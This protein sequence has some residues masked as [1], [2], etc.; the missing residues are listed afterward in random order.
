MIAGIAGPNPSEGVEVRLLCLCC[1][2]SE[3]CV[4]MITRS[5][6]SYSV[7]V[8]VFG[9]GIETSKMKRLRPELGFYTTE[10][11]NTFI[12]YLRRKY[13]SRA[14]TNPDNMMFIIQIRSVHNS[15]MLNAVRFYS[16]TTVTR[17]VGS[18]IVLNG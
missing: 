11:K 7:R 12:S 17:T 4:W 2:D 5:E 6:G 16:M 14:K 10:T 15:E 8:C 13:V 9:C 3:L 1:A 18:Q